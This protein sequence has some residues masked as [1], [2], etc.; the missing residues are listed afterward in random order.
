MAKATKHAPT[1][2]PPPKRKAKKSNQ[3]RVRPKPDRERLSGG[4][5]ETLARPVTAVSA[6]RGLLV[7]FRRPGRPRITAP[8]TSWQALAKRSS[9]HCPPIPNGRYAHSY[10]LVPWCKPTM[11]STAQVISVECYPGKIRLLHPSSRLSGGE[12]TCDW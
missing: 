11:G 3:K 9:V 5:M 6:E 2:K 4:E 10:K 7:A 8:A 12:I 1:A